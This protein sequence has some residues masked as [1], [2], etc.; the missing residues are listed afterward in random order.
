MWEGFSDGI[1]GED[2][3]FTIMIPNTLMECIWFSGG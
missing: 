3:F 1:P 2:V